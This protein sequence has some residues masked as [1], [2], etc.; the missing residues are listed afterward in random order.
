LARLAAGLFK[1]YFFCTSV[2]DIVPGIKIF[3][4]LISGV[5]VS[6]M[7]FSFNNKLKNSFMNSF[8]YKISINGKRKKKLIGLR[9]RFQAGLLLGT[10]GLIFFYNRVREK[11]KTVGRFTV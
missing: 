6:D 3:S 11:Y 7:T 5:A 10:E 2:I 1:E 8:H 4:L 9:I